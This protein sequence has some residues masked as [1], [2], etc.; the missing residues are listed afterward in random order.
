MTWDY[1]G[2]PRTS[3]KDAVRFEVGDTGAE[4]LISDEEIL[5]TLEQEAD[6]VS[7]AAARC[8]EAIAAKFMQEYDQAIG[9]IKESLNQRVVNF[10]RKAAAL[11]SRGSS[12]VPLICNTSPA[13]FSK[14]MMEA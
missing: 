2:D 13:I 14:S 1:S 9:E 3:K 10:N 12:K 4:L 7:L 5:Y 6:D 8:C 11:R